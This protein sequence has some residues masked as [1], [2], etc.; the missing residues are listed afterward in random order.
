MEPAVRNIKFPFICSNNP[1]LSMNL[2][3]PEDQIENLPLECLFSEVFLKNISKH[4]RISFLDCRF[5]SSLNLAENR[6]IFPILFKEKPWIPYGGMQL[7]IKTALNSTITIEVESG[8]KTEVLKEIFEDI[9]GIPAKK[10]KLS[11][12]GRLLE[13]GITMAAMNIK[14][15]STLHISRRMKGG[16]MGYVGPIPFADI[17]NTSGKKECKV[18]SDGPAYLT[19]QQGSNIE[20]IC[21]NSS[22]SAHGKMVI[23]PV[24][25]GSF[26]LIMREH[27]VNCPLCKELIEPVTCG[28]YKCEYMFTGRK[29]FHKGSAPV[30]AKGLWMRTSPTKYDYYDPTESGV[31]PWIRLNMYTRHFTLKELKRPCGICEK[32]VKEEGKPCGHYYHD[33]C[34]QALPEEIKTKDGC[35]DCAP[36]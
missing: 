9:F 18:G 22:C 8:D 12:A 28:F 4:K 30:K 20:G 2:T 23:H 7:S 32:K 10:Q 25:M 16:K 35:V 36:L 29:K 3:Y 21:T 26:D 13:D 5:A 17:S 34:F 24:G 15:K 33:E 19:I 31:V 14:K 6:D 27:E 1:P 11:F